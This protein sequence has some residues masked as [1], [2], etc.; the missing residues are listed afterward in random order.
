MT[1]DD[2]YIDKESFDELE[3]EYEAFTKFFKSQWKKSRKNIRKEMLTVKNFKNKD[4]NGSE[5]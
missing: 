5:S 2:T 4:G 1:D 3:R